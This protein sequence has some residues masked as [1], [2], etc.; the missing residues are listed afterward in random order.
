MN[1]GNNL[2]AI[3]TKSNISQ[4]EVAD[5]IGVDRKTYVSWKPARLI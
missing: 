1:I 2:R 3:R 5:F 4:Q